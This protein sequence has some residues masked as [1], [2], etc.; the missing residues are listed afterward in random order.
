M[1]RSPTNR[2]TRRPTFGRC[3]SIPSTRR[4]LESAMASKSRASSEKTLNAILRQQ[5]QQDP[6]LRAKQARLL[7]ALQRSRQS[8]SS[9]QPSGSTNSGSNDEKGERQPAQS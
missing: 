6:A 7:V 2:S 1:L 9:P 3:F 4:S 8:T 5:E